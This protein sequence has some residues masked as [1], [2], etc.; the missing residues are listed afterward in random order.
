[1][2]TD[3]VPTS[4]FTPIHKDNTLLLFSK[5][6][7]KIRPAVRIYWFHALLHCRR[8]NSENGLQRGQFYYGRKNLSIELGISEQTIRTI[9]KTL[10]K[11]TEISQ[12]TNNQG[13]LVTLLRVDIYIIDGFETNKQL[14][15]DQ[16]VTNNKPNDKRE[17]LKEETTKDI[18][19]PASKNGR[20][21][22]DYMDRLA[23][24]WATLDIP[25]D[26]PYSLFG[27]WRKAYGDELVLRELTALYLKRENLEGKPAAY[28]GTIL[29]NKHA[30][31]LEAHKPRPIMPRRAW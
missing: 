21:R 18:A 13:T 17:T 6:R 26:P 12:K 22:D 1:M 28:V 7:A 29:A 14:T 19:V 25:G 11:L 8:T 2:P 15:N 10:E 16:Q 27:R 20:K 30:E 5:F 4:G 9:E 3:L 23:E 31:Y 24:I